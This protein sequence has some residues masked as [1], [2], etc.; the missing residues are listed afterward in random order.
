MIWEGTVESMNR[1]EGEVN[2]TNEE[3]DCWVYFHVSQV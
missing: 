1:D 3:K 2:L